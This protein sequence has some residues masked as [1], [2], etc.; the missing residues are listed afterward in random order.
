MVTP[1]HTLTHTPLPSLTAPNAE[2]QQIRVSI[3]L[4]LE[5]VI[6]CDVRKAAAAVKTAGMGDIFF[7][8]VDRWRLCLCLTCSRRVPA[9]T[10][11]HVKDVLTE[12]AH[13]KPSVKLCSV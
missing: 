12:N 6:C 1:P 13:V 5:E 10:V 7:T 9:V 4:M 8:Q 2:V 11:G 3:V